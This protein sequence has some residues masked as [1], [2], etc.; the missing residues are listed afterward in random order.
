MMS[1]PPAQEVKLVLGVAR[2]KVA[3]AAVEAAAK[4]VIKE[5]RSGGLATSSIP[6]LTP[7]S[8]P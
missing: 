4:I 1:L 3:Q 2:L 5:E 6:E 8:T 7:P